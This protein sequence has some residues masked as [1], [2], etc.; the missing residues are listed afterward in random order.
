MIQRFI[1]TLAATTVH[2]PRIAIARFLLAFG[3][4]LS[5]LFNDMQLVANHSYDK[6][7]EYH[8]LHTTTTSVPLK[9]LDIFMHMPPDAAKG[10]AIV[11]LLLVMTGMAPQV[12]GILHF[13]V[14]FSYHNYFVVINGGDEIS[15]VLSLL[16][17]PLCLSDPRLNQWKRIKQTTEGRNIAGNI[18]LWVVRLQAAFIYFSA[19]YEKIFSRVWK[20]GTAVYYYT[21]HYRLGAPQWLRSINE[22]IT[23]TPA[24]ALLSWGT[25]IFEL[26]LAACLFLPFRI[27]RKF[28]LPGLAFH[29]LIVI[30]FG[31]ITFFFTMAGLLVLLLVC[32][33]VMD[34]G[35]DTTVRSL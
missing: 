16:L 29:F 12:T 30:N 22:S 24:V 20:D 18:A 7:P 32:N 17:L 2:T 15:Y 10:V 9:Q 33:P 31:L 26:A 21:S 25:I 3:M 6:L 5:L 28:L 23:L 1:A 14:C 27:R 35:Q 34:T 11:V 13:I 19:G 4:L 8:A